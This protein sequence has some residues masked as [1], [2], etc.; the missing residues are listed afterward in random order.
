MYYQLIFLGPPGAGKGTQA[1]MLAETAQI[2]HIST[3]DILRAAIANDTPLGQ[4]AKSYMDKGDLVPDTLVSN[5]VRERL[6]EADAKNGW[7]LDGFPRTVEQ[8]SFLDEL[9]SQ[10]DR[11]SLRVLNLDVPEQVLIDRL[12][13]RGRSQD[14]NPETIRYRLEVYRKKTAPLIDYYQKQ[15]SLHSVNGDRS[16]EDVRQALNAIVGL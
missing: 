1:K 2:P 11:N 5:M 16:L 13:A 6:H 15:G 14:D 7:I 8:A 4:Q 9:L 3:G 10:I 12:V